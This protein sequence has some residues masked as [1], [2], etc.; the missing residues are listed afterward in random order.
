MI[1]YSGSGGAH[2]DFKVVRNG[3]DILLSTS[4]M[5]NR[6][7]SHIHN[8]IDST[9][10]YQ[11]HTATLNLLDEPSSTSALT[12]KLQAATPNNSSFQALLNRSGN[13]SNDSYNAYTVS[14]IT[15]QEIG[16]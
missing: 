6:I 3:A 2:L 1:N 15:V 7:K 16:G 12:Y 14:T 8:H 4:T 9:S 10:P 13:D 5:G 11:I